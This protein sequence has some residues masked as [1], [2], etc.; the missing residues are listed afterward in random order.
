MREVGEVGIQHCLYLRRRDATLRMVTDVAGAETAHL[1][2]LAAG[3]RGHAGQVNRG[4]RIGLLRGS[5]YWQGRRQQ[6]CERRSIQ[7]HECVLQ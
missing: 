3:A 4:W 1:Q 7:W 2:G 6:Q 5:D